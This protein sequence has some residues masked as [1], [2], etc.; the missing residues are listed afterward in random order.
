MRERHGMSN[1]PEYRTWVAMN[2]RCSD[3]HDVGYQHYG[4]R[5]IVVCER[6][7]ESFLAFYTDMGAR[8]DGMSLDRIDVNGPYA[9]DN[10]RWATTATQARN[11]RNT[12]N[13]NN[14]PMTILQVRMSPAEKA[15]LVELADMYG[16]TISAFL[17]LTIAYV[18]REKPTLARP[19]RATMRNS[20][21]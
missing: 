1:T 7:R 10:C 12:I 13:P 20:T 15:T 18:M 9:P 5:G 8:P 19:R 3:P 6:W 17:R 21:V 4:G 2:R 11:R 14:A 16:V